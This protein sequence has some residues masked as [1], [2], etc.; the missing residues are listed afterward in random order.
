MKNLHLNLTRKD[1]YKL[2]IKLGYRWSNGMRRGS[3]ILESPQKRGDTW[4]LALEWSQALQLEDAGTH[5]VV[6]MDESFVNTGHCHRFSWF[7]VERSVL[8]FDENGIFAS[9]YDNV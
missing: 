9:H 8:D 5:V 6:Y 1:V 2:M 4:R 7:L 3:R